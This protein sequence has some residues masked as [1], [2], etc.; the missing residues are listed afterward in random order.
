M[1]S[2]HNNLTGWCID[3]FAD[4]PSIDEHFPEF[5]GS[6][7]V[8]GADI[9]EHESQNRYQLRSTA[10][11]F[12]PISQH[13]IASNADNG[14]YHQ[15]LSSGFP[16][17][18]ALPPHMLPPPPPSHNQLM[19]QQYENGRMRPQQPTQQQS[20]ERPFPM[21]KSNSD[22]RVLGMSVRTA[23]FSQRPSSA[24]SRM[25]SMPRPSSSTSGI[26]TASGGTV[27]TDESVYGAVRRV[28]YPSLQGNPQPL[29]PPP[30]PAPLKVLSVDV[31][32]SFA[33]TSEE[34]TA[35]RNSI[36]KFIEECSAQVGVGSLCVLY[37]F[38]PRC[39][40]C[41]TFVLL[42]SLDPCR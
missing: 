8:S 6:L 39:T 30:P 5:T 35:E 20:R 11:P 19:Q 31:N 22:N 9:L 25:T 23:P 18:S 21:F 41:Y 2:F 1:L 15:F 10:P 37:A 24:T 27:D 14:Y 36:Y 40:D 16:P 28:Y 33:S 32:G 42:V 12:E 29:P 17:R 13:G 3:M 26:T 34:H 4:H 38:L 7:D